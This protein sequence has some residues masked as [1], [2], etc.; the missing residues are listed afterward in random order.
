MNRKKLLAIFIIS[1]FF[2][3]LTVPQETFAH[4]IL[5]KAAPASDSQLEASPEEVV[6]YFNERLEKELYSI[7]V[8]NEDG[9]IVS[10]NKTIMSKDQK[11]IKQTLPSLPEG[12]YAVTYSILSADG[13][14]VKGS[15]VFSIGEGAAGNH[16]SLLHL[17]QKDTHSAFFNI[18][19]NA[20]RILYFMCLLLT[21]GWM[22]WGSVNKAVQGELEIDFRRKSRY[23][24][25]CLL[26]ITACMGI[27]QFT[28]L[29]NSWNPH[30]IWSVL[31]DTAI[32]ISWLLSMLLLCLGFLILFRFKWIDCLWAFL[33]LAV[34]SINGHAMAVEPAI[35]TILLDIIHLLAAAIWAG[36]L[37]YI[38]LY[39][40]KQREHAK[41]F[42]PI[43]SQAA[44]I[45]ILILTVT[46]IVYTLILLP[47]ISYI[48]HTQWGIMLF[49]KTLVVLFVIITGS[50]LRF[51]I[52]KKKE[53]SLSR[54][55][56]IDFSLMIIILAIVGVFTH[57]NPLPQ[58]EP[59]HWNTKDN[60]IEFTASILPKEPGDNHFMVTAHSQKED[61][62]IKRIEL[63]L[64]NN[65]QPDLAPIQVPF[66]EVKQSAQ[67]KYMMDGKYLPFP[68]S[69]TAE[70]RILDSED[71]EQV[72]Q[73]D[74]TVY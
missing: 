15:Y 52:Q 39:W 4:A 51:T 41:R 9:D 38:V 58:N 23:M 70:V 50:I 67:V 14:P 66:S 74:F 73:T 62:E 24:Q 6:L 43:F 25:I 18:V 21:S 63:F 45:S 27:L 13:H 29:L 46:G 60:S 40:K 20:V 59:L 5:E 65:D 33:V 10:Q 44:L 35:F 3:I 48:F 37:F 17:S 56:K 30:D 34:T 11:Y 26:I 68:G 19:N 54:L 47:R 57:L 12:N 16:E 31:T 1:L 8:L 2:F 22:I 7:K 53:S 42:L 72:Y 28:E 69:W 64:I 36:G 32:G 71:N 61:V 55:L 49:I